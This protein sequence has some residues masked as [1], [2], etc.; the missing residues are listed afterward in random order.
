VSSQPLRKNRDFII[1]W[2]GQV[3]STIGS[4]ISAL[5]FP[6]LVL[7]LTRSP[8]RAGI[9]GFANT[10]PHLFLYLPAGALVDRWDRKR[11]MLVADAAR[12]LA[13]SSLVV[14]LA[15][16]RLTFTQIVVVALLEGSFG[17]FFRV[18]ESAA[19]PQVVPKEQL[20]QAIAQNQARQ[21][22]AG[23]VS[24][25]L[26]GFLF[27]VGRSVPFLTDAVSYAVSFVSLLFVRPAFQEAR[28]RGET[29]ML[30]DIGEGIRFLWQQTFLRT[31]FFLVAGT[32]FGHAALS[33]VL[34]VRARNL[35][36]SSTLIGV[37]LAL[38]SGGALI[39]AFIAPWVQRNVRPSVLMIG[40]LWL[41]AAL[42]YALFFVKQ[43]LVL[44]ALC[45][46]QA[47]VGPPWNVVI[48]A[49]RYLLVPDRLLGRVGA[50]G[51]LVTWGSIP[52]GLL[53]AGYL[54]QSF[55]A[56]ATFLVLGGVFTVVAVAAVSARV[57]R[58]ASRLEAMIPG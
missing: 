8:A 43:P 53:S 15:M 55:G 38:F 37:M 9:V 51:S 21:Q 19:L 11:I 6:L 45:G 40:S 54:I 52:L 42:T 34:I 4:E 33:L 22:A 30:A 2:T 36:A 10:L 56:R 14:A 35:G 13:M 48:G 28:E 58:Q 39:G 50:A 17:V 23:I 12:A 1:L 47:V 27:A 25:P 24:Q 16:H 57:I 44:G 32:N 49:Y 5:A 46:L 7:A 3:V 20:P 29:N 41:W 26:G 31:T 18:S